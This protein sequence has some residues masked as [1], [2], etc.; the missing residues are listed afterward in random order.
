MCIHWNKNKPDWDMKP[1][2]K[3]CDAF[4][5]IPLDIWKGRISHTK[6]YPGDRG[7][8]FESWLKKK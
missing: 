8:Q 5:E 4:D 1:P 6:P 2:V 7:I 3:R